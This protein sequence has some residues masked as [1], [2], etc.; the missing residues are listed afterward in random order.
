MNV[1]TKIPY[2]DSFSLFSVRKRSKGNWLISIP[3]ETKPLELYRCC[4]PIINTRVQKRLFDNDIQNW[5]LLKQQLLEKKIFLEG[6]LSIIIQ[7]N[8]YPLGNGSWFL[9]KLL[10]ECLC[11]K[12]GGVASFIWKTQKAY[13]RFQIPSQV[14][15]QCFHIPQN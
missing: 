2:R 1:G 7:N 11:L 10:A 5:K 9:G 8:A 13:K 15:I 6:K 4:N 12:K 3:K 14:N